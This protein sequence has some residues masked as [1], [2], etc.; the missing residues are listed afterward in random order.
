MEIPYQRLDPEILRAVI[1]E[2]VTREGT[3]YGERVYSLDEK[4][5]AVQD[6]LVSGSARIEFDTESETCNVVVV[7]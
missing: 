4:V 3:D 6:Q 5:A 7:R 1:V 2:F